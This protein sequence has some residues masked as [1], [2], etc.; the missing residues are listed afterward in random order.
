[1]P[2]LA[3]AAP[4]RSNIRITFPMRKLL[5]TSIALVLGARG[6]SW[7]KA[8]FEPWKPRLVSWATPDRF[9]V[10]DCGRVSTALSGI[11]MAFRHGRVEADSA[12]S[13]V[14]PISVL[15]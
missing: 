13:V 14:H 4:A 6:E 12:L 8:G 9:A 1:M 5:I 7:F 3:I 11:V 15:S 10:S 2:A